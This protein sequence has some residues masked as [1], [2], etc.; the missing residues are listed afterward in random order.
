[1]SLYK[2]TTYRDCEDRHFLSFL[3]FAR[4]EKLYGKMFEQ[5]ELHAS[6]YVQELYIAKNSI[7]TAGT[8]YLGNDILSIHAISGY[9]P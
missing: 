2:G 1:M 6:Q 4:L 5:R 3:F 7:S 8:K 9:H